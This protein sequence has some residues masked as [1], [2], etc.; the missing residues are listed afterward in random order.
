LTDPRNDEPVADHPTSE[1]IAA[2]LSDALAPPDL[3]GLEAHLADC[4]SC[5][6]EVATARRLLRA[7]SRKR[8]RWAVPA[9]AAAAVAAMVF[10]SLL[11]DSPFSRGEPVRSGDETGTEA[12]SIRALSPING[13]PVDRGGVVFI[14]EHQTG[15]PLY[16]LTLTDGSARVVWTKETSDSTLRLPA[17][18]SLGPGR[19]YFWLVDALGADGRSLTTRTQRFSTA[20]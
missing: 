4:R 11:P 20:P 3:A 5:R 15:S 13:D 18:V 10:V 14:W 9:S 7:P 1:A 16:R 12:P 2:Y 8:L 19:T 17:E 6:M